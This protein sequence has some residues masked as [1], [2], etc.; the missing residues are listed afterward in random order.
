MTEQVDYGP[1][2]PSEKVM[3]VSVAV[4]RAYGGTVKDP[5]LWRGMITIFFA[6]EPWFDVEV[7]LVQTRDGTKYV[8]WPQRAYK[9]ASG[10][11]KYK[12]VFWMHNRSI[13]A[14]AVQ[15][16]EAYMS[17]DDMPPLPDE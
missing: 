2:I 4:Q 1:I 5:V 16:I 10:Q 7:S 17:N 3:G 9:D 6:R 15:A 13:A 8:G 14:T 12:N 11:T